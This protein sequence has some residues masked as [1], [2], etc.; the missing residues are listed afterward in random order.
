MNLESRI[1]LAKE[2]VF[3]ENDDANEVFILRRG[4][5]E[6]VLEDG[7]KQEFHDGSL[8][9]DPSALFFRQKRPYTVVV[10]EMSE[11]QILTRKEFQNAL[12]MHPN[13][14]ARVANRLESIQHTKRHKTPGQGKVKAPVAAHHHASSAR[15]S[16]RMSIFNMSATQNLMELQGAQAQHAPVVSH[17]RVISPE[18]SDFGSGEGSQCGSPRA[19]PCSPGHNAQPRTG[20]LSTPRR[21]IMPASSK[22]KSAVDSLDVAVIDKRRASSAPRHASLLVPGVPRA[23]VCA[24]PRLSIKPKHFGADMPERRSDVKAKAKAKPNIGSW[25]YSSQED[26]EASTRDLAAWLDS[27]PF[28]A[29]MDAFFIERILPLF[30]K[31]TFRAGQDILTAGTPTEALHVIYTGVARVMVDGECINHIGTQAIV[32]E[33]A[34][35]VAGELRS[36]AHGIRSGATVQ[37]SSAIVITLALAKVKVHQL[38][39]DNPLV[40]KQFDEQ[41][42]TQKEER[43]ERDFSCLKLLTGCSVQFI[44]VLEKNLEARLFQIGASLMRHGDTSRE[45]FL[46]VV[47]TVNVISQ[48]DQHKFEVKDFADA[49]IFGEFSLLG[50][51][52]KRQSSVTAITE[53]RTL[54]LFPE[55][56]QKTLDLFPVDSIVFRR[57]VETLEPSLTPEPLVCEEEVRGAKF[58]SHSSGNSDSFDDGGGDFF[59]SHSENQT[60]MCFNISS[61]SSMRQNA[62]ES[63]FKVNRSTDLSSTAHLCDCS[64]SFLQHVADRLSDRLYMPGQVLVREG[65]E[66]KELHVLQRGSCNI[67]FHDEILATM[68]APSLVG[69]LMSLMTRTVITSV[70]AA[71]MCFVATISKRE[72]A[73]CLDYHAED[74]KLLLQCAHDNYQDQSGDFLETMGRDCERK[75]SM[76]PILKDSSTEFKSLLAGMV[77]PRLMLPGQIATEEGMEDGIGDHESPKLYILFEGFCHVMSGGAVVGTLRSGSMFGELGV[78]GFA[79]R[80]D[81]SSVVVKTVELCKVG[82]VEKTSLFSLLARFPEDRVRLEQLVHNRLEEGVYARVA[83]QQCFDGLPNQFIS[84][85]CFQLNRRLCYVDEAIV[86][87]GMPGESMFIVN[88]GKAEISFKGIVIGMLWPG[89]SFGGGQILGLA[90]QYHATLRAKTTCHLLELSRKS[91]G[92]IAQGSEK[93]WLIAWQQRAK[94]SLDSDMMILNK[95]VRE[96]RRLLRVGMNFFGEAKAFLAGVVAAWRRVVIS[97]G[98]KIN[99]IAGTERTM[100]IESARGVLAQFGARSMDNEGK[101]F[102]QTAAPIKFSR[103]LQKVELEVNAAGVTST[104][105]WRHWSQSGRMD[106]WKG[107]GTPAWLSAVREEIPKQLM[108]LKAEAR[109]QSSRLP[110]LMGP[111]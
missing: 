60:P 26:G 53:C 94:A 27:I 75:L 91:L 109:G 61:L 99:P 38:I 63:C 28:F 24:A 103:A 30:E 84:K 93:Q 39:V 95:K 58:S 46:L 104:N 36:D 31:R 23:S 74:R 9:G 52:P 49:V 50:L 2:V 10:L 32:G 110:G 67:S 25:L 1:S 43:G 18:S 5:A 73:V 54:V 105:A 89:K 16:M 68:Q 106:V 8:I 85:V 4:G 98:R 37:A 64:V 15:S 79:D 17:T 88:R 14:G 72:F 13:D 41:I 19:S 87:E 86:R 96:N 11:L 65:G 55:S 21:S 3:S 59:R 77:T 44:K 7:T 57:L 92:T 100:N 82:V 47:G 101:D 45:A 80:S 51:I 90:K 102:M 40:K 66:M 70:I 107:T 56:L 34:L 76:L 111:S 33:R 20:T 6:A 29:N 22:R 78:W 69:S 81:G 35:Q 71:E 97:S 12:V 108:S 42:A 48:N 62:F 83:H